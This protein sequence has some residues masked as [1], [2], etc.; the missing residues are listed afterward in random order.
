MDIYKLNFDYDDMKIAMVVQEF[1][2][3]HE[4]EMNEYTDFEDLIS[5]CV[6]IKREW[7]NISYEDTKYSG[8][9]YAYSQCFAERY[10]YEKFLGKY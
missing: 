10:L 2:D 7:K 6:K 4:N 9:E 8:H 1:Y 3:E 5:L